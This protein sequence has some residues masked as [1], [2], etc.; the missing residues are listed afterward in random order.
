[1]WVGVLAAGGRDAPLREE[2]VDSGGPTL[3]FLTLVACRLR[4][5]AY[6]PP[7]TI[8][9]VLRRVQKGELILPAIQREYV[10]RPKQVV[11]LFDSLLRGYPIGSFLSWKLERSTLETFRFYG[12][13]KDYSEF[14]NRHNPA[15]DV[16]PDR[17]TS[18][19]LD[20]QQRLTSLNIGLRGTYAYRLPRAWYNNPSAYPT[21]RLYLDVRGEAPENEAGLRYDFRFLTRDKLATME[22]EEERFWFKV[23]DVFDTADVGALMM[24]LAKLQL[25][26]HEVAIDMLGRLWSAVHSTANLHFYEEDEQDIERVLDIFIRVNSGGTVLSYSDLLL[27]IA[28]AQWKNIDAREAVNDLVDGLNAT[29]NRFWFS[30]DV[31]LKAGLVLINVPDIGFKVKNFTAENMARLEQEWEAI[32]ESLHVAAGLL[33]DF[34]LSGGQLA[35]DSVLIPVA[36]YVHHRGLTQGY[37]TSVSEAGDRAALRSWVLR[38]LVM[39]GVWGSGLDS[40]LRDLRRAIRDHGDSGFPSAEIERKMAA[41]GKSLAVGDE[42][43]DDLLELSYGGTRTFAVL[44]ALFPHVDTRNIHH[45]DHVFPASLLTKTRLRA[46]GLGDEQVQ[47]FEQARDRLPNLQLLEGIANISKS[48]QIPAA[49]AADQYSGAHELAAYLNRNALPV[50]PTAVEDFGEFIA[51]RRSLLADVIRARLASPAGEAGRAAT[52]RA[53]GDAP[54]AATSIDEGLAESEISA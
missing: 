4:S 20:G 10:W 15:L 37:R 16:A 24:R 27:S 47:R 32:G 22:A 35:V 19:I 23:S 1:M 9:D 5:V 42:Q 39:R 48:D 11:A 41:L 7:T 14:D 26:N 25:G 33:H 8:A 28:T 46:A 54:V 21:Q 34:G 2:S 18:A 13:M 17:R 50:L 36:F 31:V 52:M 12:F 44:A 40:L 3:I 30:K 53:P 51:S 45:V 38:S 43:I 6:L 29:G 49:W